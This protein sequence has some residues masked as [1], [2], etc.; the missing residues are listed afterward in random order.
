VRLEGGSPRTSAFER[1]VGPVREGPLVSAISR[2]DLHNGPT[3]SVE[4]TFLREF[5]RFENREVGPDDEGGRT[6]RG[7]FR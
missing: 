7:R 5:T 3:G 1:Y 2:A 4:L 6:A